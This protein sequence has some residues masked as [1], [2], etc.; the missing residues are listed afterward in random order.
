VPLDDMDLGS[1]PKKVP[2][3]VA[4]WVARPGVTPFMP[5]VEGPADASPP[6]SVGADWVQSSCTC[7][8]ET[9]EAHLPRLLAEQRGPSGVVVA[10]PCKVAELS[11][12]Q[13]AKRVT[14]Y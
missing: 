12:M 14:R 4:D 7:V 5:E 1:P 6:S 11:K 10:R 8:T 9:G 3:L 13:F 2:F